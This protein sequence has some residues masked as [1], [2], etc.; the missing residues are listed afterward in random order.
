MCK[1]LRSVETFF[2]P[3]F[4]CA[5]LCKNFFFCSWFLSARGTWNK[6]HSCVGD[7]WKIRNKVGSYSKFLP[8]LLQPGALKIKNTLVWGMNERFEINLEVTV[9]PFSAV[10]NKFFSFFYKSFSLLTL[11]WHLMC[12]TF[13]NESCVAPCTTTAKFSSHNNLCA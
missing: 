13:S 6:E 5:Q 2:L 12:T 11:A 9:D 1:I 4:K 10:I 8:W 7:E 3:N